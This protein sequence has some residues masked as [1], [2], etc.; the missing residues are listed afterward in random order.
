MKVK[1]ISGDSYRTHVFIGDKEISG[2]TT[3]VQFEQCAGKVPT[4]T[5]ET[6]GLPDIEIDNADIRFNFT[7]ETISDSVKVIF[8]TYEIDNDFRNAFIASIESAIHDNG[9][10]CDISDQ[11]ELALEIANRIIGV[12]K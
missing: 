11:H 12:E 8:H 1:I 4:F 3:D 9:V 7:P 10:V 2:I 6:F 5:F